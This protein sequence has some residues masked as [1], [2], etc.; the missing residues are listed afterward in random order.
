ML[1]TD[2]LKHSSFHRSDPSSDLLEIQ[3]GDID[4]LLLSRTW[5]HVL[6]LSSFCIASFRKTECGSGQFHLLS[7]HDCLHSE[8]DSLLFLCCQ[9]KERIC[10]SDTCRLLCRF[11]LSSSSSACQL[12]LFTVIEDDDSRCHTFY[13]PSS[14]LPCDLPLFISVIQKIGSL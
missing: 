7:H 1:V 10:L 4:L 11:C 6:F 2:L 14:H 8:Y 12:S 5:N 13:Y 9:R 3:Y